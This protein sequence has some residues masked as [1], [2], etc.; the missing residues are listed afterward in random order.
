MCV[1]YMLNVMTSYKLTDE[2]LIPEHDFVLH[3]EEW[4]EEGRQG[5]YRAPFVGL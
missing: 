5:T 1:H 3:P 4:R 2:L